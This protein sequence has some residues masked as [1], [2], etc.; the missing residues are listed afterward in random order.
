MFDVD[1]AL[2]T[3]IEMEASDLHLK[4]PSKPMLRRYEASTSRA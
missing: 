1:A 3:V 2:L 4:V